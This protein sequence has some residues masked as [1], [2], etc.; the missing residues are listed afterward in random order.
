M[1]KKKLEAKLPWYEDTPDFPT[2]KKADIPVEWVDVVDKLDDDLR[3][4]YPGYR[5][6][7]VKEK[8]GGLRFYCTHPEVVED[9]DRFMARILDAEQAVARL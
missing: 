6:L 9:R 5:V 1:S 3:E 7:Q 8:F 2:Y 4:L